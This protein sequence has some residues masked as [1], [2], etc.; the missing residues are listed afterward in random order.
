LNEIKTTARKEKRKEFIKK[1]KK[2]VSSKEY[3]ENAK[4]IFIGNLDK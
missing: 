2:E 4:T 1:F 3:D